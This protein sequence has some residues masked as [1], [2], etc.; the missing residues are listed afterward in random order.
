M[1]EAGPRLNVGMSRYAGGTVGTAN[2]DVTRRV[3]YHEARSVEELGRGPTNTFPG[4]PE[5]AVS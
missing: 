4:P 2:A 3:T 1:P 5:V